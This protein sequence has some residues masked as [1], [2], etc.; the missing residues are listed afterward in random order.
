VRRKPTGPS[1]VNTIDPVAWLKSAGGASGGIGVLL[2]L[3]GLLA[4]GFLLARSN[5][6]AKSA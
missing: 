4:A 5:V 2:V 6:F 1:D 3:G